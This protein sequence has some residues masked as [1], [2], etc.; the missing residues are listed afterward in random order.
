[1]SE[2]KDFLKQ[3]KEDQYKYR[4]AMLKASDL[5]RWD[6]RDRLSMAVDIT[7]DY[8]E[9][10]KYNDYKSYDEYRKMIQMLHITLKPDI[11]ITWGDIYSASEDGGSKIVG[12]FYNMAQKDT[13]DFDDKEKWIGLGKDWLEAD[14]KR[15]KEIEPELG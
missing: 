11:S 9:L 10:E 4:Y 2:L 15:E 13:Q 3:Q 14:R 12:K 8:L 6:Y 5:N 7:T 1:M